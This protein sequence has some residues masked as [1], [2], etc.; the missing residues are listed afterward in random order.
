MEWLG[1]VFGAIGSFIVHTAIPFILWLLAWIVGIVV[2][3]AIIAALAYVA[4]MALRQLWREWSAIGGH[5]LRKS[6]HAAWLR[7]KDQMESNARQREWNAIARLSDENFKTMITRLRE[8]AEMQSRLSEILLHEAGR[9]GETRAAFLAERAAARRHRAEAFTAEAD[10]LEA[11][12]REIAEAQQT[13]EQ[14]DRK[15]RL[16]DLI[17]GLGSN[18]DALAMTALAELNGMGSA[19]EWELLIPTELPELVRARLAKI[20]RHMAQT[21]SLGE[22]RN[23]RAQAEHI[24]KTHDLSWERL[25]A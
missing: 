9:A 16:S 1:Q 13:R 4:F 25:V 3:V 15:A 23:A 2:V 8:R 10:R 11:L 7:A 12:R 20:L 22:A 5:I 17:A 18:V 19:I 21:S 24:L 14:T 6:A